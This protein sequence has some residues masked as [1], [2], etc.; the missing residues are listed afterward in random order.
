M[1]ACSHEE[2]ILEI[3]CST[4]L[5]DILPDG[6]GYSDSDDGK[7]YIHHNKSSLASYLEFDIFIDEDNSET[8]DAK[9][10]FMLIPDFSKQLKKVDDCILLLYMSR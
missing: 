4:F 6:L 7:K 10:D 9:S 5:G 3:K 1:I 8:N 2:D